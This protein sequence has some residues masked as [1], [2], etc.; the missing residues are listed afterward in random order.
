MGVL[1]C[2]RLLVTSLVSVRQSVNSVV[3]GSSQ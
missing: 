3:L 1:L 2:D